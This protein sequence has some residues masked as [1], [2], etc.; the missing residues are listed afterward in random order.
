MSEYDEL[1]EHTLWSINQ[2]V[3]HG[4]AV[5]GFL[6]AVLSNDLFQAVARADLENRRSL[7]L[8]VRYVANRCP[9]MCHGSEQ[10][11]SDWQDHRGCEGLDTAQWAVH[12][13]LETLHYPAGA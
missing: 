11:V 9:S 1:P 10:R 8:I 12:R 5:G 7:P 6:Q 2:Y 3:E 13:I 4:Q